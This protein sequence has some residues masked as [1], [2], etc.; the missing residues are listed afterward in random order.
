M[1]IYSMTATFG[2]LSHETLTLEPGMNVIHGSNEW[3]K[4][5]WC[6]FLVA[7]L[8][9]IDTGARSKKDFL[10]EKEHYA[11]WSG[12]PM[13]G[14][15]DIRWNDRDITIERHTKGRAVFG[16]FKAYETATGL[17][18]PE[19][20]AGN[21][22]Q[23]L[24]GVEKN[25]FMRAGFLRLKDLPVT[26]DEA[27]RR[28]L[29]GLVTTG[30]ESG[31]ADVLAGKL[32]ELKNRCRFHKSGLLPQAEMQRDELKEKLDQLQLLQAQMERIEARQETLKCHERQLQNHKT[33]LEY[34]EA[35]TVM[36]KTA[37][38]K[39]QRDAAEKQLA[40]LQA[41][42]EGL[43]SAEQLN[44]ELTQVHLLTDQREALQM[45]AQM[46]PPMPAAPEGA[47]PFRGIPPEQALTRAREDAEQ[48][49]R[50]QNGEKRGSP[51]LLICG[52]AGLIAGTV[53][54]VL[55]Q[56]ILG[57]VLLAAGAV[58]LIAGFL[59]Q[60]AAK[61]YNQNLHT[62]MQM[63]TQRYDPLDSSQWEAE[64]KRYGEDVQRYQAELNDYRQTVAQLELRMARQ[65]ET[66]EKLTGGKSLRQYE[67]ELQN[68]LAL[69]NAYVDAV[70]ELRRAEGVV[71]TLESS[72]KPVKMPDVEDTMDYSLA[73][74]NR[75]LSD[76]A[77]EQK[78]LQLQL[79]QCQG[80]IESLGQPEQLRQQLQ[81]VCS[82]IDALETMS[83]ALTIAQQTQL[84][85]AAE[86]QRR[87]APRISQRA[88]ELFQKLTAGRYNRLTLAEDLSLS[89][90]AQ[91]ENTLRGSLW[92]SDGTADQLYLALRLAV[93]E[94]LTP[95]A[96]LVLD[97]AL[98]RF[99]DERLALALE[100]LREEART[101]QVILFT[102][103][104]REK[105]ING[106]L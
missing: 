89:A 79:G 31:A 92:R 103:Q 68:A 75:L 37:E 8:Y 78:R 3:G 94:E 106:S 39:L 57:A 60:N 41:D 49:A 13:S 23:Q 80:Q 26:Q 20:T 16:D 93:A 53:A 88:Q 52:A 9:G 5:T 15:M 61:S 17:A 24:L 11:P 19:L 81:S 63:L 72:R 27:L 4:S 42:C 104:S 97:D 66:V 32:K 70:R 2:K 21:C 29:N 50:M 22:G 76:T 34:A 71:Q 38:A 85:A 96:P 86:L 1:R 59:Q 87:F 95:D 30:D 56:I 73:E 10:A 18:V 35:S 105:A 69:Q 91:G 54:L 65:N 84:K 46:Q 33:A 51:V 6:A 12:E 62:R 64:A 74:T 90:G 14:R 36:Q 25:V 44:Y 43:P 98:V 48:Y 40:Q 101:K 102:C 100:I 83:A 77:V 28:R 82:R 7:M 45:E 47:A 99:D 58:T 55:H 67:Q